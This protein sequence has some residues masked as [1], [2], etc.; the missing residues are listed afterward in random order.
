MERQT[1]KMK[2]I[3]SLVLALTLVFCM[4]C[5][6]TSCKKTLEGTY[7]DAS[8]ITVYEFS[9]KA[10]TLRVEVFGVGVQSF[11]G[12]YKINENKGGEMTITFDFTSEEAEGYTGEFDFSEVSENGEDYISIGVI[13][14]N[15][16]G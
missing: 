10:V 8:G 6:L 7:R 9:K 1:A 15:K 16:I 14:Y 3:L 4:L 5:T 11:E 13:R 12:T 2:K